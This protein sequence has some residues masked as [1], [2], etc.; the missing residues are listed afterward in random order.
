MT[1]AEYRTS[2]RRKLDDSSFDADTIDE[3]VN[4]YIDDV[5]GR[6][7]IR[8][9][10]ATDEIFV[11]AGDT[12]ADFPD[13]MQTLINLSVTSPTPARNIMP[14]F[15]EYGNFIRSN[16][17][18]TSVAARAVATSDWTDFGNQVR[19]GAP[20]STDATL[21]CEYMRHP[22]KMEDDTD[23]CELPDN[24]SEMIV[25]GATAR[26]MELNEDYEEAAAE[27]QKLIGT[28]L[29]PGLETTFFKNEARG[30]LK[31]GPTIMRTNRGRV[32]G[33]RADRD[34]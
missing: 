29:R 30:R 32:G 24:Y 5:C 8:L 23:E 4:W 34:F 13:D 26:V 21:F 17:G 25:I 6:I 18:Y 3:A 10:E 19:F 27:R 2:V 12:E 9:M 20:A 15:M 7:H 22:V 11:G 31:V 14:N 33:Y 28:P 1:Q 16:P